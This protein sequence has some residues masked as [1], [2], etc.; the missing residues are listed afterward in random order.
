MVG[1][2]VVL[3]SI[4]HAIA[5]CPSTRSGVTNAEL[6]FGPF[7]SLNGVVIAHHRH[8]NRIAVT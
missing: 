3:N 2:D 8:T 1:P 5:T 4:V 6:V 7:V